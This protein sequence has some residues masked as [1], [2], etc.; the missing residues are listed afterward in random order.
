MNIDCHRDYTSH[1]DGT[2]RPGDFDSLGDN[3]I[4]ECADSGMYLGGYGN[5]IRDNT[6]RDCL[7]DGIRVLWGSSNQIEDNVLSAN[8]YGLRLGCSNSVYRG[9][10]AR[11]NSTA[12]FS[13]SGTG[14]TSHGDNYMPGQM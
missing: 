4:F 2:F 3:V 11:D 1:G 14:N 13:D 6:V 12:D 7:S 10:T 8:D 5:L 9:N